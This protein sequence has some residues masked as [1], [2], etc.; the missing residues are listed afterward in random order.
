MSKRSLW[1]LAGLV[2]VASLGRRP[3]RRPLRRSG[4]TAGTVVLILEQEPPNL[5]GDWVGNGLTATTVRHGEHL[6]RLPVLERHGSSFRSASLRGGSR[7]S[8]GGNPLTVRFQYKPGAVW[9]DGKPVTGAD[10]RATWQVYIDPQN[11]VYQPDGLG[12]HPL[13]H[14]RERQDGHDRVQEAARKLG[15]DRLVPLR[16]RRTSSPART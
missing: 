10:Y 3:R 4:A 9:S 14:G 12:G 8:S 7:E 15:V 5:Q 6:V 2:L 1:L 16:S 11:N 13:R